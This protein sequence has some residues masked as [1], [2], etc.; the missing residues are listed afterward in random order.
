MKNNLD[1]LRKSVNEIDQKI[2]SLLEERI[3]VGNKIAKEKDLLNLP[4][5]DPAREEEIIKNL[6]GFT[7]DQSLKDF[8]S[9]VYQSIFKLSKT[10]RS[11]QR[12][13]TLP[14]SKVGIL[15]FGLIGGSI[16]KALR[17]KN[18]ALQIFTVRRE[19]KSQKQA[20]AEGYI[21]K[22]FDNLNLMAEEI[23]LLILAVP[24]EDTLCYAR[25]MVFIPERK[26]QNKLIVIDVASVKGEIVRGFEDQT[27]QNIEYI[28]THPMAGSEKV[29]FLASRSSLFVNQPWIITP[30]RKNSPDSIHKIEQFIQY[31]GATPHVMSADKH[32]E[33]V[34][35]IS[36]L[37]FVL[38]VYFFDFAESTN[39]SSLKISG[40]G[41]ES[42]TRLASGSP[43]MHA[44]IF[45][46][47]QKNIVRQ[48][49]NFVNFMVKH[50]LT[51]NSYDFFTRVKKLRD[52]FIARKEK[53]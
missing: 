37:V 35:L 27:K 6:T 15:G 28:G 21:D 11:K 43:E 1:G 4:L 9:D 39:P 25:D 30:H 19:S 20:L 51:K 47:N 44:D 29:G 18:P 42:L 45:T 5:T 52:E 23:D 10:V 7:T 16:A 49:Q 36:H 26:N 31:V 24:I 48:L 32:D 3:R 8:I 13:K 40:S 17:S 22:T 2:I 53:I 12:H 33:V 46:Q 14:F 38:S 50:D 34:A 41:F